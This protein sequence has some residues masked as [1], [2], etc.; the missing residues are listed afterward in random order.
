MR[1][2]KIIILIFII[3]TLGYFILP[4]NSASHL[5]SESDIKLLKSC[6]YEDVK[7]SFFYANQDNYLDKN[8]VNIIENYYG[9]EIATK[10]K[11]HYN[12]K[13]MINTIEDVNY[14][15]D[16]NLNE[17]YFYIKT[18]KELDIFNKH[19]AEIINIIDEIKLD[20]LS[21][22][23][24]I[25]N[26]M[27]IRYMYDLVKIYEEIDR[28][29]SK[30]QNIDIIKKYIKDNGEKFISNTDKSNNEFYKYVYLCDSLNVNYSYKEIKNKLNGLYLSNEGGFVHKENFKE[31]DIH[32]T[33]AMIELNQKLQPNFIEKNK[34]DIIKFVNSLHGDKGGY[35]FIKPDNMNNDSNYRSYFTMKSFYDGVEIISI[36]EKIRL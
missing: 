14:K 11:F 16:L 21:N 22:S 8:K 20:E 24:A 35:F 19:E 15:K 27:K 4:M 9:L 32:S 7:Y 12:K 17:F 10:F 25:S 30:N 6:Y 13:K 29:D 28:T 31:A 2:I 3:I 23:N 18:L 34:P 1:K 26:P 33:L 36:L 5:Y